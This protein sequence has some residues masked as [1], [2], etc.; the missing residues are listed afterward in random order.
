ML[1]KAHEQYVLL[2]FQG[3]P[4]HLTVVK[5]RVYRHKL[6]LV[7]LYC[8]KHCVFS[9][10]KCRLETKSEYFSKVFIMLKSALKLAELVDI[11]F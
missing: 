8:Y 11:D 7:N 9:L 10:H 3:P 4:L 2:S 6:V 1:L 5:F